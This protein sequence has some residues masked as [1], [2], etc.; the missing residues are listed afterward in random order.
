MAYKKPEYDL[1]KT[2]AVFTETGLIIALLFMIGLVNI[3]VAD[4]EPTIMTGKIKEGPPLI[5]PP[6]IKNEPVL[7]PPPPMPDVP[8]QIPDDSPIEEPPLKFSEFDMVTELEIPPLEDEIAVEVDHDLLAEIEVLPKMIGGEEALRSRIKYPTLALKTGIEGIVEVEFFVN[9]KGEV[10][11]PV[12]IQ[13]IGGGCD[14]AV[15]RAIQKQRYHPG[16]KNGEIA[17]FK[18]KETVQ[19]IIIDLK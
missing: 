11:D 7:I 5:L 9:K 4:R 15:L 10:V 18:I 13:G 2:H 1:R 17:E 8:V 3:P 14:Q 19:F 6:A 16:V 12:I